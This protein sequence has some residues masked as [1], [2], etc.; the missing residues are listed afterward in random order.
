MSRILRN[1][2]CDFSDLFL[3]GPCCVDLTD[4]EH[5]SLPVCNNTLFKHLCG[6]SLAAWHSTYL[7]NKRAA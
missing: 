4:Q 6:K 3:F 1:R 5:F 2:N 7:S